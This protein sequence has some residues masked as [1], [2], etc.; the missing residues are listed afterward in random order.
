MKPSTVNKR[1]N[2]LSLSVLCSALFSI[3]PASYA[4]STQAPT[5]KQEVG[6][7][8]MV[9]LYGTKISADSPIVKEMSEYDIGGIILFDHQDDKTRNIADP[10]QLKQLTS[11]LQTY[12]RQT[13][14]PPLLIGI[15][16]EGGMISNL[17]EKKGFRFF[18]DLSEQQLGT[19]NFPPYT[20]YQA[21]TQ[22]EL[23]NE[24]GVNLDFAPVVDLN[25]NPDNPAIGK[26]QTKLRKR[27]STGCENGESEIDGYHKAGIM[28][29]LKH[30]PGLG[31]ASSNTDFNSVDV[32]K[33]W[34]PK[35]LEPYQQLIN[36]PDPCQFIMVTHLINKK[37]DKT[38]QLASLSK[39]IVTGLLRNKIGFK[40]LII[41]DDMDAKAIE[42]KY[43]MRVAVQKA[44][45]A[46]NDIILVG[47]VMG[48]DPYNIAK[49]AYTAIYDLAKSSPEARKLVDADY[50]KIISV[51]R[52]HFHQTKKHQNIKS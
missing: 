4:S 16:Q 5:L 12:A 40:G 21:Y 13:E 17:K 38:G 10:K 36:I 49:T 27:C 25:I 42:N 2:K 46:G 3:S 34:S 24:E 6:Q 35:E 47:G 44:V 39:P 48:N 9:G 51:K 7:M 29:T 19:M 1:I 45:L 31:S 50:Q 20:Q 22:G 8:L 52:D 33:T 30:F 15:D 18:S 28:C 37:L 43:D 32:T 41:T 11:D 23:M 26:Y 14:L